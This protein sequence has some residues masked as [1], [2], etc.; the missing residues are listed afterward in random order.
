MESQGERERSERIRREFLD[1]ELTPDTV[2]LFLVRKLIKRA[3]AEAKERFSGTV[4]DIGCGIMP[5]REFL[6]EQPSRVAEYIGVDLETDLYSADVDFRW[7]GENI[8]LQEESVQCAMATEVLE[9]CSN[10]RLLLRE[11]ERVL[12]P[13]GIFFFTVPFVWPLDDVPNDYYRYTSF[14]LRESLEMCSF[15]DIEINSLGGWDAALAQM[16]GLWLKRSP[17][18][19]L[20]S[21][22]LKSQLFALYQEL[23][24]EDELVDPYKGNAMVSG[25]YGFAKKR[26]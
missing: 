6:L 14:A 9:H 25:W 1:L 3:V 11:V 8:P 7:D 26:S 21:E 16:I 17:Q 18:G 15:K 23:L 12:V 24:K 10:P 20:G 5:Y 4:L 13:G 2:D 19:R 22:G